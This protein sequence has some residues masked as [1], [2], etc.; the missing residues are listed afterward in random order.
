V[1]RRNLVDMLETG[2]ELTFAR[3][4]AVSSAHRTDPLRP[5]C[6]Q[7][8]FQFFFHDGFNHPP[9]PATNLRLNGVRP[10]FEPFFPNSLPAIDSTSG[11][12][13]SRSPQY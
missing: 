2:G 11:C 12:E 13:A 7:R 9:D 1:R 10:S 3:A 4:V 6:T 8:R 5:A